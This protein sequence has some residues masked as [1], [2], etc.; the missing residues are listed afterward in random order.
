[1]V[2][3]DCPLHDSRY[4][5]SSCDLVAI[6]QDR[7]AGKNCKERAFLERLEWKCRIRLCSMP[8]LVDGLVEGESEKKNLPKKSQYALMRLWQ[9]PKCGRTRKEFYTEEEKREWQR[10]KDVR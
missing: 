3:D 10:K 5:R 4:L 6:G 8:L 7:E 9:C 1:M 2:P